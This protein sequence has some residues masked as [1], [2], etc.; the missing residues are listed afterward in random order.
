[1]CASSLFPQELSKR[2]PTEQHG[3]LK[4]NQL[5]LALEPMVFTN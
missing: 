5:D 1:L 4:I 3:D 2:R